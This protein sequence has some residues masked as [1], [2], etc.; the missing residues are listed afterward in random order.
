MFSNT[1]L[2]CSEDRFLSLSTVD[3]SKSFSI[4]P[5]SNN[6]EIVLQ[7]PGRPEILEIMGG[8]WWC[9]SNFYEENGLEFRP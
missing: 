1:D 7:S 8:E 4:K 2:I 5:D 9:Y 6:N 3:F